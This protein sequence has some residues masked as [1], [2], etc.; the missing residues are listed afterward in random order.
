MLN[1]E[2]SN[3]LFEFIYSKSGLFILAL[4]FFSMIA[5]AQSPEIGAQVWLE[6]GQTKQ[7]IDQLFKIMDDDEMRV[8][9]VF[10][11]WNFIDKGPQNWDFS[12]YDDAF[13]AAE[14]YNIKMV[15]TLTPAYV[16][17]YKGGQPVTHNDVIPSSMEQL[18]LAREYIQRV[19]NRYKDRTSLIAWMQMNEPGGRQSNSILAIEKFHSWLRNKYKLIDDLNQAWTQN[20]KTFN[21]IGYNPEWMGY[22]WLNPRMYYDWADFQSDYLTWYLKWV[23]DEVRKYD[24]KT[25]LHLNP[26]GLI[27][28]ISQYNFKEWN[29]VVNSLGA[30]IH[31]SWHFGL[32]DRSQYTLGVNYVCDLVR[33]ANDSAP[34]WVTE[35]Q[36]GNNIYSGG[37]PYFTTTDDIDQWLFSSIFSGAKKVIF[38][39]LNYRSQGNEAGEWGMLDFDGGK[40]DNLLQSRE[41]SQFLKKNDVFFK[42]A[43][44]VTQNVYLI[45][46]RKTMMQQKRTE[47]DP[48]SVGRNK[49]AH[50]ES[51]LGY[52]KAFNNL[53]ISVELKEINS[54]DWENLKIQSLA[55]LPHITMLEQENISKIK[56]FVNNGNTLLISGLSALFDENEKAVQI[57][58]TQWEDMLGGKMKQIKHVGFPKTEIKLDGLEELPAYRWV[59]ELNS[60]EAIPVGHK[61]GSVTAISNSYGGGEVVW[62]PSTIGLGAWH[63]D[64]NPLS[65]FIA[66][67]FDKF[68]I[69]API[70]FSHLYEN[71]GLRTMKNGEEYYSTIYNRGEAKNVVNISTSMILK[72]V[73]IVWGN[74]GEHRANNQTYVIEAGETIILK[75]RIDDEP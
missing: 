7:H 58:D 8:A 48:G 9:R 14:K 30:S 45:Y 17:F 41:V 59:G 39:C 57:N 22:G 34:F 54:I 18:E 16:P 53:G 55:V 24:N 26:H 2:K 25:D 73:E 68:L 38:W 63:F 67:R 37:Q 5:D 69:T 61:S 51:V 35:L 49:N 72:D 65:N 12:L 42:N 23:G 27:D 33:G 15:A 13:E 47:R 60:D 75:Y 4:V 29:Q 1:N 32:L 46:S 74:A 43:K 28:N 31:P 70:R 40:S 36:G 20:Y 3:K 52:Y 44:P 56:T 66:N 6:P 64:S 50:I 11:M 21:E 71:T 10:V 19:V 62:I